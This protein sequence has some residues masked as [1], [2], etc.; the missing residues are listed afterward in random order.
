MPRHA[1]DGTRVAITGHDLLARVGEPVAL[2]CHA[3]STR[4]GDAAGDLVTAGAESLTALPPVTTT[5]RFGKGEART[6]PVHV[7]AHLTEVGTLDL[8]CV[9]S[10]TPHRWK[11]AFSLRDAGTSGAAA[12]AGETL[13]EAAI[14]AARGVLHATFAQDRIAPDRV[15]REIAGAL[16]AKREVWSLAALRALW[17]TLHDLR[18]TRGHDGPREARWLNLTGWCLRPG[19]GAP[20]DDW[21]VEALWK[22]F[23][24][25]LHHPRHDPARLEWWIAWRRV[26]PGLRRAQ[27]QVLMQQTAALLLPEGAGRRAR[28]RSVGPRPGPAEQAE[29]WRLAASLEHAH[30]PDRARFGDTVVALLVR[31]RASGFGWWAAGRFGARAPL[32]GPADRV[33]AAAIAQEWLDRLID[34]APAA[35]ERRM[36]AFA[37]ASLARR[38]GDRARDVSD[39]ARERVL[40]VLR[41]EG[42]APHVVS[43]VDEVVPLDAADESVAFGD[44]LPL[45]LR[46][47]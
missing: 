11:L 33:V 16:G 46:F 41:A 30:A 1:E 23:Q 37:L 40:R 24:A 13:P 20:G 38:T 31:G 45:G 32:Y 26:S 39:E 6:I 22:L 4:L 34:V 10:S 8:Y 28:R 2:Q 5:L 35:D 25:G 14:E 18:E 15:T 21:R 27:Q 47:A 42:A 19:R 3:S 44:E 7:E 9:S 36:R 43:L 12:A 29:L 17:Q